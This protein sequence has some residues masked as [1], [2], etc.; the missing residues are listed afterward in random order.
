MKTSVESPNYL[1]ELVKK[2][3]QEHPDDKINVSAEFRKGLRQKLISV[4]VTVPGQ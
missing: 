3:N 1:L 4:G 2:Y